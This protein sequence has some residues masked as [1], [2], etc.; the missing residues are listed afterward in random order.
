M[1]Y[2][3]YIYYI[4]GSGIKKPEFQLR[5]KGSFPA[6]QLTTAFENGKA[7]WSFQHLDAATNLLF[8][9]LEI[10]ISGW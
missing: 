9:D 8:Q 4:G 1:M 5:V 3:L 6:V 2:I 10:M 7:K